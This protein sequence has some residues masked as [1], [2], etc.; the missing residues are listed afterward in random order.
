MENIAAAASWAQRLS[1]G[2]TVTEPQVN[3]LLSPL[4]LC[5]SPLCPL[6]H[7][8]YTESPHH[9]SPPLCPCRREGETSPWWVHFWSLRGASAPPPF[10]M[11]SSS[12]SSLVPSCQE[13]WRLGLSASAPSSHPAVS[14]GSFILLPSASRRRLKSQK[15]LTATQ[16]LAREETPTLPSP[17]HPA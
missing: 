15:D 7:W 10:F 16:S 1:R 3:G 13:F 14:P 9:P 6:R 5:Y 17:Q 4:W 12:L 2:I 11:P 8:L